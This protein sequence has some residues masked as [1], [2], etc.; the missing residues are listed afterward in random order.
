MRKRHQ[1]ELLVGS[2][3]S[4]SLEFIGVESMKS[5]RN[6]FF[7]EKLGTR[8]KTRST[9]KGNFFGTSSR[10]KLS[11]GPDLESDQLSYSN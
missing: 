10:L 9:F 3:T 6:V 8:F 1:S 2:S 7:P 4:S 11:P 5:R